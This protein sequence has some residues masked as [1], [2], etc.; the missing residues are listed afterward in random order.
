[1]EPVG[2]RQLTGTF[3]RKGHPQFI[4]VRMAKVHEGGPLRRSGR[5][6]LLASLVSGAPGVHA[7]REAATGVSSREVTWGVRRAARHFVE[8]A[9]S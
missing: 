3:C 1:M 4:E 8:Y 2:W 9:A 5:P 7:Q 6:Q